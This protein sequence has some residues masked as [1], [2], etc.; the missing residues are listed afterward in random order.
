M[1]KNIVFDLA[2]VV[3]ARNP[4]RFPKH[5]EEFFS[6]VFDTPGGGVPKF[7][8]NY[9]RGVSTVDEVAEAVA[10]YR[11]CDIETAKANMLLAV[12]YQEE[13]EPTSR[14]VAELKEKG[15]NLYIL[16]N[17]SRE[18]ID[19]LREMPVFAHFDKQIISCEVQLVKPERE[20]Y[21]L[22]L[23]RYGLKPNETIFIDDREDNVKA[24][25]EIGIV[26]FHFD[27]K[28]PERACDELRE[29]IYNN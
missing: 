24:A 22:L 1:L 21:E 13:V 6:F 14:L 9:D 7:W 2:G 28:N 25:E 3:V 12:E 4:Q 8:E 23:S 10:E 26:P 5:L 19:F 15:Y 11:G 16:S 27:R 20:M 29:V 17:M 18:Y